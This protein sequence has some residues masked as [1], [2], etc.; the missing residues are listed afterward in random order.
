MAEG[1]RAVE[2]VAPHVRTVQLNRPDRRKVISLVLRQNIADARLPDDELL[3]VTDWVGRPG[4]SKCTR[5]LPRETF[6]GE[7]VQV[8]SDPSREIGVR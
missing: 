7:L 6:S 2:M 5:P 3:A 8:R 1:N 4:A